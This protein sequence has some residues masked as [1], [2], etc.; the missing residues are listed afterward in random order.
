M[1]RIETDVLI[2][3]GGG[4]GLMAAIAATERGVEVDLISKGECST[5]E[6]SAL[7]VPLGHEDPKDGPE[8]HYE[9]TMRGGCFIN[10]EGLVRALVLGA[11]PALEKLEALGVRFNK[12]GD[13]YAQRLVSD[14]TYPRSLFLDDSLG[15]ELMDKLL[16]A[17][18]ERGVKIR[19]GLMGIRLLIE[20]GRVAGAVAMDMEEGREIAF[21]AKAIVLASGGAGQV[22]RFTTN[23]E[24]MT[25]DGY[26]MAYEAGAELV[27]MEFVQFEPTIVAHPPECRGLLIPT[28]LLLKGAKIRDGNGEEFLHSYRLPKSELAREIYAKILEG[29]CSDRGTVF[30]DATGLPEDVVKGGFPRIWGAL[31]SRGVD[32]CGDF[33]EIA[34]AAHY[35]MGGV[36]IDVNCRTSIPGLYAAGEVAGGIHGANR[37]AGNSIDIVVFGAKA[38]EEAAEWAKGSSAKGAGIPKEGSKAIFG[39]RGMD[40]LEVRRVVKEVMQAKASVI[41]DGG[42]LEEGLRIATGLRPIKFDAAPKPHQAQEAANMLMVSWMILWAALQREESR[43]SHFR[44]D[45]PSPKSDWLRHISIRKDVSGF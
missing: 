27:D 7:N 5:K 34:P 39:E 40:P 19:E 41:R 30:F 9:D 23:A 44:R 10:D 1:E 43:G 18:K 11:K 29:R 6:I 32:L 16:R 2:I 15:I 42:G 4:A 14:S 13:L 20:E 35:M 37:I 17:T 22:Y 33:V 24:C 25:G 8:A 36:R 12:K 45:H 38:G 28:A 31:R 21:A 26:A 3:G